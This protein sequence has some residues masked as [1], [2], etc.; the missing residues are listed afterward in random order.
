MKRKASFG[1]QKAVSEERE[2]RLWGEQCT[3][4]T[5]AEI[6]RRGPFY[7]PGR[8][9]WNDLQDRDSGGRRTA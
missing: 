5:P 2:K 3:D 1:S 4:E 8:S 9:G 6:R 7:L